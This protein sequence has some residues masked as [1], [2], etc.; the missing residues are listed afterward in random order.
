MPISIPNPKN[1]YE[2]QI[3]NNG[4]LFGTIYSL[5]RRILSNNTIGRLVLGTTDNDSGFK[6][7]SS[8]DD[9]NLKT[10]RYEKRINCNY[11][12]DRP[13]SYVGR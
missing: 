2:I 5:Q 9:N 11:R 7:S 3:N 8:Y 12:S 6:A 4:L 13:V 1:E 10:E